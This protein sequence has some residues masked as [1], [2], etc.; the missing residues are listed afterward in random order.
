[1]KQM[2][3]SSVISA[4]PLQW[5]L[6]FALT[7]D[8]W[9]FYLC[10][11]KLIKSQKSTHLQTVRKYDHAMYL[12]KLAPHLVGRTVSDDDNFLLDCISHMVTLVMW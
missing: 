11:P 4:S 7:S 5:Y 1:M 2:L 10:F 12:G 9:H 6:K 3:Q 8:T